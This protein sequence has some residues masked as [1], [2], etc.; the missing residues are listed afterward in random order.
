MSK[1]EFAKILLDKTLSRRELI[2]RL[3]AL[4]IAAPVAT[5]IA[6]HVAPAAAAPAQRRRPPLA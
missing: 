6:M 4:G 1:E 2:Q 5:S 3:T